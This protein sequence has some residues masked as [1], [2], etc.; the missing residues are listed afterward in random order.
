MTPIRR[1]SPHRRRCLALLLALLAASLCV[2]RAAADEKLRQSDAVWK[3]MDSCTR[4]AIKAYPDYTAEALAKREVERRLCL[5]RRNLPGA[6]DAP[7]PVAAGSGGVS[8]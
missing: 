8:K 3:A 7:A 1:I 6:D 5:R 2:G 4:A